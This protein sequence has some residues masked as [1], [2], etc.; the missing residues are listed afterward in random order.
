MTEAIEVILFDLG[1][2]LVELGASPVPTG[3]LPH[4]G[5]FSLA[6]WFKSDTA[7][8]FEKGTITAA[9]FAQ[10]MLTELDLDCSVER[11]IE[12]FTRWP[13]GLFPGARELLQQLQSDYR[14]AILTNTNELHWPRFDAEFGLHDYVEHIF[15]SHQLGLL[16]PEPGIY[17]HVLKTLNT[18]PGRILFLDDNGDNVEGARRIG[19]D[20]HQVTGFE[21]LKQFLLARGIIGTSIPG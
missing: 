15:A 7:S 21:Q 2:V 9:D 5:A 18:K 13:Q 10:S 20:A 3:A 8:A 4:D 1:G 11:L 16:K 14:L 6:E 17:W 12:H 19:I